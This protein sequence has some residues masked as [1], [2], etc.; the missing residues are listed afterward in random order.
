MTD[1]RIHNLTKD[2]NLNFRYHSIHLKNQN[3]DNKMK[4]EDFKRFQKIFSVNFDVMTYREMLYIPF[5]GLGLALAL[6]WRIIFV[7][8][9]IWKV[10]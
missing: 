5:F 10:V 7:V 9:Y 1:V 2:Q 3:S 6:V 8:T 4:C